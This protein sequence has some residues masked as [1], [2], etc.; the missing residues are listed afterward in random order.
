VT[1]SRFH[2]VLFLAQ[3]AMRCDAMRA[4]LALFMP[5]QRNGKYKQQVTRTETAKRTEAPKW[6]TGVGRYHV[7]ASYP[8]PNRPL[9]EPKNVPTHGPKM[10]GLRGWLA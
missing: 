7:C 2:P 10:L 6:R 9:R 1:R 3:I 5:R 8:I 4:H